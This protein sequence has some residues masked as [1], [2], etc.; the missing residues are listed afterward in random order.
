MVNLSYQYKEIREPSILSA[1][2]VSTL[3]RWIND[4]LDLTGEN[5]IVLYIKFIKWS[6]DSMEM[7]I[8]FS[9]DNIDY[10]QESSVDIMNGTGT[11]NKFEYMFTSQWSYRVAVPIKDKYMKVSI[12]GTGDPTWSSCSIINITWQA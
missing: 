7:K 9:P 8:E 1:S 11:V 5:Q 6:L 12:K 10:Y 3:V 4:N 2:Y